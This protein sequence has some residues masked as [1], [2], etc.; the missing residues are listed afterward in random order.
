[1]GFTGFYWVFLDLTGLHWIVWSF[2]G[3]YRVLTKFDTVK[4]GFTGFTGLS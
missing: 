2:T 3:F 4:L 1:M